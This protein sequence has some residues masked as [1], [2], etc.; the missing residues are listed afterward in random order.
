ME[1]RRYQRMAVGNLMVDISDGKG[2]FS[3]TVGDLSRSGLKLDDLSNRL[4]ITSKQLS[5]VVSGQGKHFK[6]IARPKWKKSRNISNNIGVEII[7]APFGWAEFVRDFEPP[8]ISTIE[9]IIM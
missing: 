2:F 5:V 9:E 1:K 3:G 4:D 8:Q 6:M 7:K